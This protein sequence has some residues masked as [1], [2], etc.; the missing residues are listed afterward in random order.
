MSRYSL[1]RQDLGCRLNR[2]RASMLSAQRQLVN[3]D[4]TVGSRCYQ[5]VGRNKPAQFRHVDA[6]SSRVIK[7]A[8]CRELLAPANSSHFTQALAALFR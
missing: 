2:N 7:A 5:N 1:G 4:S 6:A 3:V 8:E